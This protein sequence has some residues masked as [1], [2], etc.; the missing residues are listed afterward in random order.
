MLKG[1]CAINWICYSAVIVFANDSIDVPVC[2]RK[3]GNV[4]E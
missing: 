2:L 4:N 1:Y 3:G